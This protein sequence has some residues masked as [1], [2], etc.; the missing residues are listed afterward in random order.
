MSTTAKYLK[1]IINWLFLFLIFI[2]PLV[3]SFQTSEL[4][5]FPKMMLVYSL[6]TVIFTFWLARSI[7]EKKLIFR[8]TP[9][10]LPIGLFL[11]SQLLATIFSIQLHTSIFG[12]YSRFHGGLLST[13]SYIVLYYAFVNNVQLQSSK[14]MLFA[15]LSSGWLIALYGI[16]EHFGHSFSCLLITRG[17]SFNDSCWVQ[18][19]QHRV[20]ATL[21]QPNWFA[22]L[23]DI[24]IFL[25]LYLSISAKKTGRFL[26]WLA[27]A[28][29]LFLSL[30]Y[31]GSRSGFL[32]VV[33][34]LLIWSPLVIWSQR[35][36]TKKLRQQFL[37]KLLLILFGFGLVVFI[38]GTPLTPSLNQFL[39]QEV[40]RVEKK[41]PILRQASVTKTK[42]AVSTGGTDSGIIREIVWRGA[43]K[44]WRRYPIFGSGLGTFGYSYYRDRPL[45][46]NHVSEWNFLYNKAHNEL[47]NFLATSGIVGL[48]AYLFLLGSFFYLALVQLKHKRQPLLMASLLSAILALSV[49]NFFGFSTVSVTLLMW[50]IFAN[51]SLVALGKNKN[52]V[53]SKNLQSS[54]LVIKNQ[55]PFANWQYFSLV[56]TGLLMCFILASIYRGY[57]ADKDYKLGN[58]SFQTGRY[59]IG[60][61][62][63][64]TAIK[65]SPQEALYQNKLSFDEAKLAL[66]LAQDHQATA[67]AQ[68]S[69]HALVLSDNV[70]KLNQQ[71]LNFYKTRARTL[72]LLSAAASSLAKNDQAKQK[73][74]QNQAR[75][76]LQLAA[77][78]LVRARQLAPNEPSLS[79]DLAKIKNA[80]GETSA[81]RALFKETLQLK[82][83]YGDALWAYG[84]FLESENEWVKAKEIYQRFLKQINP[85][86]QTIQARLKE[87]E[88]KIASQSTKT[89]FNLKMGRH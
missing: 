47:L 51:A 69:R 71:Q 1:F 30:L 77:T 22:A 18:D 27:I 53:K 14:K 17:Q 82:S 2:T 19:V 66:I 39:N 86:D 61:R 81:A 72:T 3:F 35:Q 44:V 36:L 31:S 41:Q 26:L 83:D 28:A 20:F 55:F 13:I 76:F 64:E 4:F 46:H 59:Q 70:I 49:S 74:W 33:V 87:V 54:S 58:S 24:L 21:G 68:F 65:K 56:L 9:L 80:L 78:T 88:T 79:L 23:M 43:I 7:L 84:R 89:K 57:T 15:A 25:A 8:A 37:K 48:V 34:G 75:N 29:T 50:L 62:L 16:L 5:E 40:S 67:A 6:T 10:D 60:L 63:L 32:A 45:A 85:N 38:N 52:L 11:A 12:Y 73:Q 42:P